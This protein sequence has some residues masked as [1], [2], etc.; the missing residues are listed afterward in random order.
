MPRPTTRRVSAF[1]RANCSTS[2]ASARQNGQ[3]GAQ[4]Q[5][6][7]GLSAGRKLANCTQSFAPMSHTVTSGSNWSEAAFVT[8]SAGRSPGSTE[9]AGGPPQAVAKTAVAITTAVSLAM[10][11]RRMVM[12]P[13]PAEVSCLFPGCPTPIAMLV[14]CQYMKATT[15]KLSVETRD[16]IRAL[17]GA[18]YE[19]TIVEALDVLEADRFWAQADAAAAWRR[20]LPDHERAR[21]A[22]RD[23]DVDV[24]FADIE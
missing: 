3:C 16:R 1:C 8:A 7:N 2:G 21:L 20:S 19:D 9:A 4:N 17:G 18:T 13:E 11:R 6:S 12:G 22:A 5:T 23:A 15:I 14:Y 24:A 10:L